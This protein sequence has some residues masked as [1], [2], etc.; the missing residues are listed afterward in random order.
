MKIQVHRGAEETMQLPLESGV[1]TR[2]LQGEHTL[3]FSLRVSS[4]PDIRVGDTVTYKG[5]TMTINKDPMRKKISRH[6]YQL[7]VT[8]QGVR[9]SLERY[10]LKD[11]GAIAF[12]YFGD[13][14]DFM[15]MYLEC[16]SE[17]ESGWTLGE[18]EQTDPVSISF[19]MIDCFSAL[20][21]IAQAFECEWQ[22]VG[23]EISIKK[24]VGRATTISLAY[25]K[26]NGLYSLQRQSVENSGIVNRAYGIG[27]A[28]NLPQGY[29][30]RSLQLAAPVEDT[31]SIALYGVREGW[32]RD[33]AIY[34][35]RTGSATAVAQ[36]NEATFVLEDTSIDFDLNGVRIDGAEAKIVFKS[37]ALNGQEFKILSYNADRKE[38][39]YEANKDSNGA[40]IPRGNIVA[41]VGDHYTLVGIRMP[42]EYVTAAVTELVAKTEEFLNSNKV[43]RVVYEL[44]IDVLDAKRK[45]IHPNEGDFIH[46]VDADLGIDENLRVTGI[47]YPALFPD[48]LIQGMKFA[49]EV[50]NDVTYT[51]VQKIEKDIKENHEV[52]TQVSRDSWENDRRNIVALNE[53]QSKVFDPDGNLENA[54]V[55]GIAGLFG[56]DSMYYDLINVQMTL[57]PDGD[58][59]AFE[60]TAGELVHKVY[61]ID[62]LGYIWDLSAFSIADLDLLKSYYLSARCSQTALT[63]E[64]VLTEEQID[65]ESESGYWHFNFGVLSS[66][67]EGIRSFRPTKMFTLISGG[68]I[69]T[70]TIS[71]YLINVDQLFAKEVTATNLT[72]S[73]NSM[74]GPF[75]I[76]EEGLF[77][78]EGN[79]S[80]QGRLRVERRGIQWDSMQGF[81]NPVP[82]PARCRIG[83]GTAII[84]L[85][86]EGNTTKPTGMRVNMG[87]ESFVAIEVGAGAISVNGV[88]GLTEKV[89]FSDGTTVKYLNINKGW[90]TSITDN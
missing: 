26:D 54:M 1:Y 69:E 70:D 43:P 60:M 24:T 7:E 45:N 61:E 85:A 63:G 29:P 4:L 86:N 82:L 66:V 62:G 46:V 76:D 56:T 49:C 75:S 65:T 9:H 31:D 13:L 73:G 40:L 59:N 18:I 48:V 87:D 74:I 8:F 19:E 17:V 14:S 33:E 53:F 25:G 71:A 68:N 51:F 37:G 79:V 41:G 38:I 64:W 47:S 72:V 16:V 27:G 11:E 42:E 12:D 21:M 10:L 67:I 6:E 20:N 2:R 57:N 50:G 83:M 80:Y 84:D 39:R 34:P 15:F 52:I 90:I 58:P 32:Y 35:K 55:Q 44:D 89:P 3:V 88:Y 23:K 5:E 78:A 77:Y 36:I 28:Q 30:F 81:P 22:I